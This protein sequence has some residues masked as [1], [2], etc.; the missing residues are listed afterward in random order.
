MVEPATPPPHVPARTPGAAM[1]RIVILCDGTWNRTDTVTPTNVVR[2]AQAMAGFDAQGIAQ[3]PI[4]VEGVGTGEG[5]T[6]IGRTTDSFL[7]GAFGLGLMENLVTAYRA[8]AFLYEPGDEVFILGFSRGAYTA[9]SLAGFIR[10]SGIV[11]RTGLHL[12]PRAVARYRT[13][14]DRRL[15]PRTPESHRFRAVELGSRVATSAAEQA[16]RAAEGLPA[17][18]LFTLAYLGVWDTVGALGFPTF[19]PVLGH[20]AR[21]KYR[22]HDASL[23]SM[24]RAARHAVALDERRRAFEPTRWDNLD[25]LNA[26]RRD[27]EGEGACREVFFAGDHGSVGGGGEIVDLSHIA[28]DWIIEGAAAAGLGFLPDARAEIRAAQNPFGP[29]RNTRQ[30]KTGV[31]AWLTG[32][33]PK[34][35]TGPDTLDE[36]HPSV[37][38]RW[39]GQGAPADFAGYRPPSL[40]RVH[41]AL[42]ALETGLETGGDGGGPTTGHA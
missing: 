38:A 37:L 3:I 32:L 20:L 31:V 16:W 18:P 11:P 21:R 25:A 34:D 36:V 14:G 9:R 13:L 27:P 24:V 22:F 8:L 2:F 12:I 1:K 30:A 10:S 5:L 19:I 42:A 28:L 6:W 15:H 35:R 17:V 33:K 41:T 26:E 23:S 7:G 4:Y 40:A 29:L 39:T